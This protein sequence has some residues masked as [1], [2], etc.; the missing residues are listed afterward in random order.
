MNQSR[1]GIH[2]FDLYPVEYEMDGE[3]RVAHFGA[4]PESTVGPYSSRLTAA[5]AVHYQQERLFQENRLTEKFWAEY[6]LKV[7]MRKRARSVRARNGYSLWEFDDGSGPYWVLYGPDGPVSDFNPSSE[8]DALTFFGE[9]M[10]D[11]ESEQDQE[12]EQPVLH[13]TR[14]M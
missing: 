2:E 9:L 11:I 4:G 12:P 6:R 3:S 14:K 5:G 13:S 8:A 10:R 7:S 1:L